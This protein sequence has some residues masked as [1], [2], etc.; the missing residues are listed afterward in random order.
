MNAHR[1]TVNRV[2]MSGTAPMLAAVGTNVEV[3]SHWFPPDLAPLGE[4]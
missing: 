4:G 1:G 2:Q 3:R